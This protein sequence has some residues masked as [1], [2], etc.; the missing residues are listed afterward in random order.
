MKEKLHT[1]RE[2]SVCEEKRNQKKKIKGKLKDFERKLLGSEQANRIK[3]IEARLSK[4]EESQSKEYTGNKRKYRRIEETSKRNGTHDG[5]KG[6]K[7]EKKE[8]II[9]L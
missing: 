8:R 6:R 4:I 2:R 1:E 9:L 5:E 3:T 7:K